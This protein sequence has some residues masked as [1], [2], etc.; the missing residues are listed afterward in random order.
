M[1]SSFIYPRVPLIVKI[2]TAISPTPAA[3]IL[4]T[5]VQMQLK[6]EF[7]WI[8]ENVY[9]KL[10]AEGSKGINKEWLLSSDT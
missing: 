5:L 7:V 8:I 4:G 9:H 2:F 6:V 3:G 1:S 10:K